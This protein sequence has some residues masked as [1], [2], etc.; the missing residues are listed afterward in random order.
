MIEIKR[1]CSSSIRNDP[2]KLQITFGDF[3]IKITA[4]NWMTFNEIIR[5]FNF[6]PDELLKNIILKGLGEW[7]NIAWAGYDDKDH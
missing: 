1:N 5:R 2:E 7:E 6:K 4:T 3:T